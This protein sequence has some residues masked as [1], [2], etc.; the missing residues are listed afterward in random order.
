[1]SFSEIV[2]KK[3]KHRN[4]LLA[5]ISEVK[6]IKRERESIEE[7]FQFIKK[8]IDGKYKSEEAVKQRI[9]ELEN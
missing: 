3:K 9:N 4:T 7:E 8:N 2:E 1:M 5:R 6:E